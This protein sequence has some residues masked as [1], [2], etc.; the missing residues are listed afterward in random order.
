LIAYEIHDGFA[1][2][3]TGALFRLQGFRETFVRNPAEAWKTFDSAAQLLCRAIDETRRLISGLR[4]PI[5]MNRAFFEAVQY[6]I[7]EHRKDGGPEIE[8]DLDGN[9]ERFSPPLE[10]AIFRIVQESINNACRHSRSDKIHVSLA[11][12]GDRICIDVRDWGIGFEPSA[13]RRT[14]VWIAGHPRTRAA[15]GRRRGY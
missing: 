10:N 5:S 3:L 11:R 12:R 7:Y 14:A 15:A 2:Q 13:R 1:Q 6:L 9:G 8:F 4:P